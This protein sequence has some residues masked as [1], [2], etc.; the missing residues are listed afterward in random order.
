M[1][2][3]GC[4]AFQCH[5]HGQRRVQDTLRE[6]G[7]P[8]RHRP[9]P[10]AGGRGGESSQL[11]PGSPGGPR[12]RSARW[13]ELPRAQLL[14]A[15]EELPEG[16]SRFPEPLLQAKPPVL[17]QTLPWGLHQ[18]QIGLLCVLLGCSF[19]QGQV[20]LVMNGAACTCFCKTDLR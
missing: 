19:L 12:S 1:M 5:V 4:A 6:R 13:K 11:N 15:K 20:M 10:S 16:Q 3:A 2:G 14:P 17:S 7:M 18:L 9:R 8:G